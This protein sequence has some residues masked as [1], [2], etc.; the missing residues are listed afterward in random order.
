MEFPIQGLDTAKINS[1]LLLFFCILGRERWKGEWRRCR[2]AQP[3]FR[4]FCLWQNCPLPGTKA[5]NWSGCC[6]KTRLRLLNILRD[7]KKR[8]MM[9]EGHSVPDWP[10]ILRILQMWGG[11]WSLECFQA[12]HRDSRETKSSSS[13]PVFLNC[14][15]SIWRQFPPEILQPSLTTQNLC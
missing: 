10:L 5:A 12:W 7:E 8:W 15:S 11:C 2:P 1:P 13:S 4:C 14:I 9:D 3:I 6:C